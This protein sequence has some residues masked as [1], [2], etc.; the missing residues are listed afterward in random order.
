MVILLSRGASKIAC[1]YYNFMICECIYTCVF[2]T[3]KIVYIF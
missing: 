2:N 3:Y 1:G